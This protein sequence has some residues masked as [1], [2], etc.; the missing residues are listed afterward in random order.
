M[1]LLFKPRNVLQSL[2]RMFFFNNF[3]CNS[4]E[5]IFVLIK[6]KFASESWQVKPLIFDIESFKNFP[7]LA[8]IFLV[9]LR[10]EVSERAFIPIFCAIPFTFHGILSFCSTSII[11]LLPRPY[12]ILKPAK[13][14]DF[15]SDLRIRDYQILSDKKQ[16][17][18]Y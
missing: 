17:F 12:P 9:F 8:I 15:V 2:T 11:L 7:S 18:R 6:I 16:G 1:K 3:F 14:N 13:P 4:F 5:F 10:C